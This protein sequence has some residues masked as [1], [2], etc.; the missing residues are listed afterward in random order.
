MKVAILETGY[1]PGNLADDFGNYPQ[2]FADMLGNGF[3]IE[4]FDVQAGKLPDAAEYHACLITGSPAGS[5]TPFRGSSLF[6][7]SS[8]RRIRRKW[9]A[10]A[11]GIR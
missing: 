11:S 9:S 5:M 3:E 1:P 2:M 10:S 8:A 7:N 6:S 4:S